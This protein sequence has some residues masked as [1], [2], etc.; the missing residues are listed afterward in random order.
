M[1]SI[2]TLGVLALGLW[3]SACGSS[4]V[5]DACQVNDDCDNGQTCYA[6]RPEGY[7]SKGCLNEGTDR[8]CPG[9]S[10][11]AMNA[12][13]LLCSATCETDEN[14]R[15]GYVCATVANTTQKACRPQ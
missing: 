2:R 13:L 3:L 12:G 8:A 5:G 14:C 1:T 10:V 11:C 15:A 7:C 9:G 4:S 6:D